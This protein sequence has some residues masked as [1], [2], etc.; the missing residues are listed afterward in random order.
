MAVRQTDGGASLQG[1]AKARLVQRMFN[2]IVPRYDLM[3]R[4]MT[5]GL[6]RRW[7]AL[8]A[9]AALPAGRRVLD[10]ATGTGDLALDLARAGAR[11]VV[12][13]D[14]AAA[15]LAAAKRKVGAGIPLVLADAQRLPFGDATF[16]A[17]TNAFLLRNLSDL[18]LGLREMRRVLRPGGRLVCLEITRPAPGPFAS[19]FALYFY[20]LVPILGGLLTG[21]RQAYR[22]LPNSLTTFPR[23]PELASRI[24]DAGFSAVTYQTLAFGT[25]ALHVGAVVPQREA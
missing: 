16:D 12:G 25:V 9:A 19:L 5:G 13:A 11:Q 7:R 20:R 8:A 14:F 6:D 4:L 18:D 1:A 22:Y 17:V 24:R 10:V 2:Q 15:M 3:N 21:E 23:A